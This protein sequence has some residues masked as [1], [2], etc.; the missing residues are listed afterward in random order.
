MGWEHSW[1]L[2]RL[3]IGFG[4]LPLSQKFLCTIRL[5]LFRRQPYLVYWMPE[6]AESGQGGD[7]CG[8]PS[9]LP[10]SSFSC[11]PAE[12]SQVSPLR[13]H[14]RFAEDAHVAAGPHPGVLHAAVEC[15]QLVE[16]VPAHGRGLDQV[17]FKDSFQ[18]KP[19][20]FPEHKV[21]LMI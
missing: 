6:G 8:S 9:R 4:F 2:Q 5:S 10:P 3:R 1:R 14:P 13:W 11:I 20:G 18:P 16:N 17:I 15:T 12:I 19:L 7:G 21:F